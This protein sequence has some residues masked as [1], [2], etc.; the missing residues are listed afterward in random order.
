MP[1]EE[2]R[3]VQQSILDRLID[4]DIGSSANE[5]VSRAQSI[6]ELKAAVRRDLEG[7]LNTRAIAVRPPE[8]LTEVNDSVYTFGV[9]DI[10]SL[11]ADDPK[12]RMKLRQMI[13]KAIASFEPRLGAVQV[14]DSLSGMS[15]SRQLRFAIQA[16]LKL[17]PSPERVSFDTV[18]DVTTGQYAIKGE[19]GAG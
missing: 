12:S 4:T 19:S 3:P 17:D 18:L 15:D 2:D 10:T 13:E 14:G 6:R 7:L 9:G 5:I 16:I 1:R 11:S 8:A